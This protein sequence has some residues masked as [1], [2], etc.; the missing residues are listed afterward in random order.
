MKTGLQRKARS[1]FAHLLFGMT[2]MALIILSAGDASAADGELLWAKRAVGSSGE[3]E[4]Y[5]I[6]TFSDD[7]SV[8]TGYFQG[9]TTFGTGTT[10][11]SASRDIFIARYNADGTL[12]WAKSA[13]GVDWD[14]GYGISSFSDGSSV[15]T[16]YFSGTATFGTGTTLV[17]SSA[18]YDIFIARYN[19]DGTL[20]WAKSAGGTDTDIGLGISTF[21]DGS[22]VVTGVFMGTATFGTGTTLVS[23][24]PN[25]ED[26]FIAR[27]N[28]DGTLAWAKRA[29]DLND[30]VESL[31]ISTFPDG[32]CVVTGR[33]QGTT[34]FYSLGT[35][36]QQT[37]LVSAGYDDIFISKYNA[38]GTLVWAN[39][40]G[41]TDTDIGHGISTFSDGTC[42][43]TGVFNGTATFGTGTTLVSAGRD[44]FVARYNA[45]GTLAWAKRAGG[46]G[47][48]VGRGISTFS[49]GTSVVTGY[50]QNTAT[51]G[52]GDPNVTTLRSRGEANIFIA[53]Y[54]ADGT[55][56]W[57]MPAVG[58]FQVIGNGI[59]TFS[60]GT[61]VVTGYFT[62]TATFGA[63]EANETTL[64][65][66]GIDANTLFIAKYKGPFPQPVWINCQP[67]AEPIPFGF[68][69]KDTAEQFGNPWPYWGWL[70]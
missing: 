51:F 19:A 16:G 65:S 15:V 33:F 67:S 14:E 70:P 8:V 64:V 34:T 10:L 45:D 39:S 68:T 60:D 61:S 44:I 21:F 69:G 12:A 48:D 56:V 3:Q 23:S 59:S 29:A 40:A 57:A 27:Y 53:R 36:G 6:S 11:V 17:S 18:D 41:G 26:I 31:G 30:F 32:T 43:V 50:F 42:V 62:N 4:G 9:T 37:V 52:P 46:T 38:Y 63:F 58:Y 66:A 22:S 49:D 35:P 24:S 2:I 55:L 54:N 28:A 5:G 25:P 1:H 7:S 47:E 20:A 13:G